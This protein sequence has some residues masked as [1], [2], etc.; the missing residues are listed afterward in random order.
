MQSTGF[1]FAHPDENPCLNA[2]FRS[3]LGEIKP[4]TVN[5][6]LRALRAALDSAVRWKMLEANPFR[7][8]RPIRIEEIQLVFFSKS[9]FQTLTASIAEEWMREKTA[10]GAVP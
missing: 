6:E 1:D 5:I 4:V 9:D 8:V 10:W 2:F 7:D 3:L